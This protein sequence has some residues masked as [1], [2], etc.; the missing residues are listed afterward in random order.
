MNFYEAVGI[1]LQS[2][3]RVQEGKEQQLQLSCDVGVVHGK[4]ILAIVF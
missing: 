3:V 1:R 2:P 4:V